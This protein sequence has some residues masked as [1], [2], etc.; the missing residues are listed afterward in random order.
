MK[1]TQSLLDAERVKS[2]KLE[3]RAQEAESLAQKIPELEEQI[4]ARDGG[5]SLYDLIAA[6]SLR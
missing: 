4:S 3:S 5:L 1:K 2:Q 6:L